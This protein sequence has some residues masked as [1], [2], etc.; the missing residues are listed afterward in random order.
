MSGQRFVVWVLPEAAS[1]ADASV[2][3]TYHSYELAERFLR[4]FLAKRPY[5]HGMVFDLLSESDARREWET[6]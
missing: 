3:G 6:E 4:R 5:M 2:V 1:L